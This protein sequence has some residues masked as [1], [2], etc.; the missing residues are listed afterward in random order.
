[1]YGIPSVYSKKNRIKVCV[2]VCERERDCECE[3]ECRCGR[4]VCLLDF[5]C[6]IVKAISDH[7]L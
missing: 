4:R 2:C 6:N 1:M 3:C 5:I 7:N